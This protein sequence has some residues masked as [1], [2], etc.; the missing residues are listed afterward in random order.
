ME[1][2]TLENRREKTNLRFVDDLDGH[3]H[4]RHHI[5]RQ[6]HLPELPLHNIGGGGWGKEGAI[7]RTRSGMSGGGEREAE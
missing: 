1:R 5:L 4:P 3:E 6:L 2:E 7:W